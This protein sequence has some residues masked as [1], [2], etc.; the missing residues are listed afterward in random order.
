[1]KSSAYRFKFSRTTLIWI[2]LIGVV[3]ASCKKDST[4][5]PPPADK[6][7]LQAAIATAQALSLTVEGTKPGQYEV[8]SKAALT[9]ALT[10]SNAVNANAG[11]SQASVNNT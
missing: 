5:P 1:M 2:F 9:A 4:P 7:A 11:A 6:V 10:A 8:G 3:L